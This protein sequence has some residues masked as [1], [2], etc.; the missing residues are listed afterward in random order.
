MESRD[1]FYVALKVIQITGTKGKVTAT[2]FLDIT[3]FVR[4]RANTGRELHKLGRERDGSR[5]R[6][7]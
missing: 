6:T 3:G 5:E 7:R 2:D 4:L 1:C